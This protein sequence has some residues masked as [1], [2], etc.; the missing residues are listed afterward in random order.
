MKPYHIYIVDDEQLIRDSLTIE[1]ESDYQ[2]EAFPD[3]EKAIESLREDPPD[4]VL[5]D[6]GLPGING[7]EALGEIKKINPDIL[8]VMIT[9]F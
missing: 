2:I 6:I 7:V 8:V 1:L 3:A 4:L 9:A 5:L